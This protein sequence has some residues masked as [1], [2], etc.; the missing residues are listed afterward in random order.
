MDIIN[1]IIN[2]LNNYGFDGMLIILLVILVIF[3][4]KYILMT[5]KKSQNNSN[6]EIMD[7]IISSN[8]EML[9]QLT[10][11]ISENNQTI[12]N[13]V[14]SQN[15]KLLN[16]IINLNMKEKKMHDEKLNRRMKMTSEICQNL[17][18][19]LYKYEANRILVLEFHNSFQ[20]MSEIPFAKYSCTFEDF[21][22]GL[23]RIMQNFQSQ[24]F[25]SIANIISIAQQTKVRN[26]IFKDISELKEVSNSLY[27]L[28]KNADSSI[29]SI[30]F[31]AIYNK[32]DKLIGF[33]TLGYNENLIPEELNLIELNIDMTK[34]SDMMNL[35]D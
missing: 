22:D 8:K 9:E 6:K 3:G 35:E 2:V 4:G 25:S 11:E 13:Y 29:K 7:K 1:S 31:N 5:L 16:H 17:T 27:S 18:K 26:L 10:S 12:T 30:I 23:S 32:S 24:P 19:I 21:T 34:I 14:N 15:D 20:N 33:I 28:I